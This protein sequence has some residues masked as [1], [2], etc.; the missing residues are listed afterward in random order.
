[1]GERKSA[2][3]SDVLFLSQ[4]ERHNGSPNLP[5]LASGQIKARLSLLHV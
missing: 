3:K 5:L 2:Q 4:G 1:M